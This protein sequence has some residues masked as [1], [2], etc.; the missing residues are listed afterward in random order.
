MSQ[1]YQPAEDSYLLS[2][3]LKEE[4]PKLLEK[5]SSSSAIYFVK[6]W[7]VPTSINETIETKPFRTSHKPYWLLDI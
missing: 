7:S 5:K 3:V 2:E 1:I 6:Y 4:L